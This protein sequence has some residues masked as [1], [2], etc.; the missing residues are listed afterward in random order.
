MEDLLPGEVTAA[1]AVRP[2]VVTAEPVLVTRSRADNVVCRL[3]CVPEQRPRVDQS[4]MQR[5]FSTSIALS[6]T[7]CILGY[8]ILP[9]VLPLVGAAS[10]VGPVIGIPIGIVALVFDVKGVRRFW[11]A[12][13][14]KRWAFTA[15]YAVIAT[16]VVVLLVG[17]VAHLLR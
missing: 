11:L 3:L 12:N 2:G 6:A 9:I 10:S 17:D 13:H 14:H 16:M 15:L 1:A 4:S 8:V 5:L 7:R